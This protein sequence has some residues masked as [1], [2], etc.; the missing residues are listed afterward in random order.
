MGLREFLNRNSVLATVLAA[1]VLAL[2]LG[3]LFYHQR[4]SKTAPLADVY[5]YDLASTSANRADGLF[6][7]KEDSPLPL[8]L[9]LGA[10]DAQ[11]TG[12]R[13]WVFSCGDCADRSSLFIGYLETWTKE[14]REARLQIPEL[15][16]KRQPI[17]VAVRTHQGRLV[18]SAD[19]IK[20][21]GFNTGEGQRIMGEVIKH[22][23]ET[24]P[25]PCDPPPSK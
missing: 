22:C 9:P 12:V 15:L 10:P 11:P 3:F 14:Y 1:L 20:W 16:K 23:G 7:A 2:S 17:P 21:Y 24:P 8:D 13:A 18:S 19:E 6:T 5:F 4:G 25:T